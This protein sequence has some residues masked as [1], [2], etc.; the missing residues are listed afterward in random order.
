[1]CIICC[2]LLKHNMK[3]E[4]AG[5]AASEIILTSEDLDEVFHAAELKRA[6]EKLDLDKLDKIIEAKSN[7]N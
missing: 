2:E 7:D 5:K 3:I 1:M 4:E 6:I